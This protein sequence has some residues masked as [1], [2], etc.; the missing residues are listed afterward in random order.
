MIVFRE[1]FWIEEQERSPCFDPAMARDLGRYAPVEGKE[2]AH[3]APTKKLQWVGEI[4]DPAKP[5]DECWVR[6]K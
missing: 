6:V 1:L 3:P 4:C 2:C 5:D